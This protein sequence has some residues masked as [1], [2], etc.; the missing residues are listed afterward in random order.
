MGNRNFKRPQ[1]RSVE[2]AMS[3]N[4]ELKI[5]NWQLRNKLDSAPVIKCDVGSE[6]EDLS[7]LYN[8]ISGKYGIR[9]TDPNKQIDELEQKVKAQEKEL[10]H[11]DQVTRYQYDI[12]SRTQLEL[13]HQQTRSRLE[14][15]LMQNKIDE[16][17]FR[18]SE[19]LP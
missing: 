13:E 16:L 6:C 2:S 12:M 18:M 8:N 14:K 7:I 15:Q 9:A 10:L 19:K 17:T 11:V 5:I 1:A 3:E 4:N